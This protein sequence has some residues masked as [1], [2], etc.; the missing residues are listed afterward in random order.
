MHLDDARSLFEAFVAADARTHAGDPA[1]RADRDALCSDPV[2][3]GL[4]SARAPE[5]P[6]ATRTLFK[7]KTYRHPDAG[8]LATAVVSK[9]TSAARGTGKYELQLVARAGRIVAVYYVCT[10]CVALGV[11]GFDARCVECAGIG[12]E[13]WLG[14]DLGALGVVT[15]LERLTPPSTHLYMPEWKRDRV[16]D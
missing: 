12:W 4:A 6:A 5:A 10:A 7:V 8:D 2:A 16:P 1:G 13:P 3:A 15:G 9:A 11:D 14:Q